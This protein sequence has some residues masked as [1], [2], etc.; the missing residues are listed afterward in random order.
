MTI[1]VGCAALSILGYI[2]FGE[3]GWL[4]VA[5]MMAFIVAMGWLA[6]QDVNSVE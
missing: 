4:G 5:A 2:V 1:A 6:I 3:F